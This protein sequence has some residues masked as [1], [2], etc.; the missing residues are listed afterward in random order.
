MT[1]CLQLLP[2]G[3]LKGGGEEVE[4]K[5]KK[6]YL[7]FLFW[8]MHLSECVFDLVAKGKETAHLAEPSHERSAFSG[9]IC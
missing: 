3:V 4:M 9:S 5:Y 8:H 1:R 2:D 7:A 6:N